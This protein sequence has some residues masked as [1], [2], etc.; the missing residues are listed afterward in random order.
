MILVNSQKA[1]LRQF[2]RNTPEND[3]YFDD[4]N[5][6]DITIRVVPYDVN[7]L[8]RFGNYTIPE[9]TGYYMVNRNVD[10]RVGDQITF[11]G[12]FMNTKNTLTTKTYTV[13]KVS[14]DWI[15]NRVENMMVAVK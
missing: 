9:A 1:T 8:I 10:V 3:P 13:L 14:D 7:D 5:Y 6:K 12:K 15:F 11:I 4:Q 2:N